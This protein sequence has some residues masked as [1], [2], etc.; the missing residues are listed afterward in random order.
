M[1]LVRSY[2]HGK[3]S[4][5]KGRL[6]VDASKFGA[7]FGELREH[8]ASELLVSYL[9][10]LKAEAYSDLVSVGEEFLRTVCLGLKVVCLDPAGKLDLFDLYCLLLHLR[11]LLSLV[12]LVAILAVVH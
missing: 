3:L 7:S 6:L 4:A 1:I 5:L 8:I 2:E 12:L 9:T 11:F 10:S